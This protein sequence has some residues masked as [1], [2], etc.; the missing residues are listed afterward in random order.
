M[1]RYENVDK[2]GN[3]TD[4][5]VVS[6]QTL[7]NDPSAIITSRGPLKSKPRSV[8]EGYDL[9]ATLDHDPDALVSDVSFHVFAKHGS[10]EK[11]KPS[12][13]SGLKAVVAGAEAK[14]EGEGVA[15]K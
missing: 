4:V 9:I 1:P 12:K 14:A 10:Y 2:D 6:E 8:P 7:K 15:V 13:L 3:V 11:E 5:F